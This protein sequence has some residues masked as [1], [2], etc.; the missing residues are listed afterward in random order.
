MILVLGCLLAPYV[1][2]LSRTRQRHEQTVGASPS[3]THVSRPRNRCDQARRAHGFRGRR[4]ARR[5]PTLFGDRTPAP[6]VERSAVVARSRARISRRRHHRSLPAAA[7]LA[8]CRF[9]RAMI[10][11]EISRPPAAS[12]PCCQLPHRYCFFGLKIINSIW[13]SNWQHLFGFRS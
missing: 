2:R 5:S 12:L 6:Q 9:I 4:Q 8:S 13:Y 11:G 7:S 3:A 1:G 10:I